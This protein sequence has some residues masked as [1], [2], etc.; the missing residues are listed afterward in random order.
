MYRNRLQGAYILTYRGIRYADAIVLEATP[1]IELA[2]LLLVQP[3]R[4]IFP[5]A[6]YEAVNAAADFFG[7]HTPHAAAAVILRFCQEIAVY[8]P[9][10]GRRACFLLELPEILAHRLAAHAVA[11]RYLTDAHPLA[12]MRQNDGCLFLHV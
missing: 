8:L 9:R 12:A 1:H 2:H 6:G 4:H 11:T 10:C 7:H 5:V 3:C